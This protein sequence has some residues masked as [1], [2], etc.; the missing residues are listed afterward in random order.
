MDSQSQPRSRRLLNAGEASYWPTPCGTASYELHLSPNATTNLIALKKAQ[1]RPDVDSLVVGLDFLACESIAV[2]TFLASESHEWK[3]T[4]SLYPVS[5]SFTP[6]QIREALHVLRSV[7]YLCFH[8][9]SFVADPLILFRNLPDFERLHELDCHGL[10]LNDA[11]DMIPVYTPLNGD[12]LQN[13]RIQP[14]HRWLQPCFPPEIAPHIRCMDLDLQ[15]L[16][17][18]KNLV[19]FMRA[20]ASLP[21]LTRLSVLLPGDES[22]FVPLAILS[23]WIASPKCNLTSLAVVQNT[24]GSFSRRL[25]WNAAAP[26]SFRRLMYGV[27]RNQSL[28]LLELEEMDQHMDG[29]TLLSALNTGSVE[30]LILK[31]CEL[32]KG[33]L[34]SLLEWQVQVRSERLFTVEFFYDRSNCDSLIADIHAVSSVHAKSKKLQE[35]Q[36]QLDHPA[37]WSFLLGTTNK[38]S[39]AQSNVAQE[40]TLDSTYNFLQVQLAAIAVVPVSNGTS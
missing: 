32:S 26:Q 12:K 36:Y 4:V 16:P 9:M 33:T 10:T 17:E 27:S 7:S 30:Q 2:A 3:V 35:D 6:V 31:R 14:D 11:E 18:G 40:V 20:L 13:I 25:D 1:E 39:P 21:K 34:S 28:Q 19:Q 5:H 23:R 37:L 38:V 29:D 15:E 24:Q 8:G 22:C